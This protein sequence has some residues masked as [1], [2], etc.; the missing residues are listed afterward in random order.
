MVDFTLKQQFQEAELLTETDD[1]I[2]KIIVRRSS[3][4]DIELDIFCTIPESLKLPDND[5]FDKILPDLKTIHCISKDH[6]VSELYLKNIIINSVTTQSLRKLIYHGVASI[7]ENC[8][9]LK[10]IGEEKLQIYWIL[11]EFSRMGYTRIIKVFQ[12]KKTKIICDDLFEDNYSNEKT[13]DLPIYMGWQA[14]ALKYNNYNFIYGVCKKDKESDNNPITF[15]RFNEDDYPTE[16]E[17]ND[18]INILSYLMGIEL[19]LIGKTTFN[20]VKSP[21]KNE[22]YSIFRDDIEFILSKNA[23]PPVSISIDFR[24]RYDIE[25]YINNFIKSYLKNKDKFP[26]EEAFWY[27]KECYK[28]SIVN[29]IQPLSTA[30]DL[31][32]D[33]YLRN[34]EV[35]TLVDVEE[36]NTFIE[37]VK[38]AFSNIKP[39]DDKEILWNKILGLNHISGNQRN[40]LVFDLL[41]MEVSDIEKKAI[42]E[43]NFVIHGSKKPINIDLRRKLSL[44][45]YTLLN[46]LILRI[47]DVEIP[48]IDYSNEKFTIQNPKNKQSGE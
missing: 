9:N 29:T 30:Y 37:S 48:Y 23:L 16:N 24:H 41:Q 46:R 8:I 36:F 12:E 44:V 5:I 6:P 39:S 15:L 19:F 47:L 33:A 40:T 13:K 18:I 21:I 27:I 32:C 25:N 31:I 43:R 22:Y 34:T 7:Y 38:I 17:I 4:F 45:F 20:S 1:N 2:E 10:T 14:I 42:R 3:K 28:Q 35:A 11:N 26:F